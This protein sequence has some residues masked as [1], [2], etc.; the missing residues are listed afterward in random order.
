MNEQ[1]EQNELQNIFRERNNSSMI[2]D[3]FVWNRSGRLW[4]YRLLANNL[5]SS[6]NI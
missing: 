2:F 3:S 1:N 6:H 5:I 4:L